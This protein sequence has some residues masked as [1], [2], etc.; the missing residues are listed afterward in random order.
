MKGAAI[1]F[2]VVY[3][4][5]V[6]GFHLLPTLDINC[7]NYQLFLASFSTSSGPV[8]FFAEGFAESTSLGFTWGI[9]SGYLNK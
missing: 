1:Y 5:K 4:G 3:I 6:L 2:L 7:I 9:P 8:L